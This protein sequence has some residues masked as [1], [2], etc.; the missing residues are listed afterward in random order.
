MRA[1]V[2]GAGIVGAAVAFHLARTGVRVKVVERD[3]PAEGTTATSFARL[4]AFDKEPEAYFRLNYA[5]MREHTHLATALPDA[6]WYHRCGSLIWESGDGL[7][8]ERVARF[9]RWGY[10]L[11]WREPAELAAGLVPPSVRRVLHVPEEGWVDAPALARSLLAE[12]QRQRA[13]VVLGEPVTGLARSAG[14]GWQVV[15]GS[16]RQLSGNVVVNAAGAAAGQVAALAG[17]RLD[18]VP[19]RGLLAD[20]AVNGADIT[21]TVHTDKVSVRPAGPGRVMVRAD[22]VDRRLGAEPDAARETLCQDLVHLARAAVPGLRDAT[23]IGARTGVRVIPKGGYPSV[24]GVSDVPGYYQAATHSGV[25]LAPL[26]GRLLA[27]EIT[28][29]HV[30]ELLVPY[31]PTSA[32]REQPLER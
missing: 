16:G 10:P 23:V 26:I 13:Q 3:R 21:Q 31:R 8:S 12:A 15:L 7:L 5:G 11:R 28:H 6:G 17:I 25:I 4:S 1:I 14:G 18:L 24:G 32:G 9:E 22:Q 20:L 29:G 27:G 2:V 30:H 19:S